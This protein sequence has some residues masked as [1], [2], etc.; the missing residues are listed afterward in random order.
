[1]TKKLFTIQKSFKITGRGY[2]IV[3]LEPL[4]LHNDI[5]LSNWLSIRSSNGNVCAVQVRAIDKQGI[6]VSDSG[7][8]IITGDEVWEI[9]N[10][11]LTHCRDCGDIMSK[12]AR[13][14]PNCGKPNSIA[15]KKE[16]ESK[17]RNAGAVFLCFG[18]LG[19][20]LSLFSTVIGAILITIGLV[21]MVLVWLK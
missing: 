15:V 4:S 7:E 20:I 11:N 14:C 8:E 13:V 17:W 21:L 10:P 12:D 9:D 1:M 19:G 5:S 2:L 18:S 16:R 3:P 6:L